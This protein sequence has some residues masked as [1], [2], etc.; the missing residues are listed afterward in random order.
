MAVVDVESIGKQV[1][2]N[3]RL[4]MVAG[5]V[6]LVYVHTLVLGYVPGL[7]VAPYQGSHQ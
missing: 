5:V 3:N 7:F 4:G 6:H 2:A 1:M